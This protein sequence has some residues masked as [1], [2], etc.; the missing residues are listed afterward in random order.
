ML[1]SDKYCCPD[2]W[3]HTYTRASTHFAERAST[4]LYWNGSICTHIQRSA[5]FHTS[6]TPRKSTKRLWQVIHFT[7]KHT[8]PHYRQVKKISVAAFLERSKAQNLMIR[9][10]HLEWQRMENLSE[11]KHWIR[12]Y[13]IFYI[14]ADTEERNDD[15]AVLLKYPSGSIFESLSSRSWASSDYK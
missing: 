12:R 2:L 3:T 11:I 8:A 7:F 6:V 9:G 5:N 13:L 4:I 1:L 15:S 14:A 10:R